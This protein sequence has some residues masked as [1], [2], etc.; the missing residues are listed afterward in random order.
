MPRD[1]GSDGPNAEPQDGRTG[2]GPGEGQSFNPAP[3]WHRIAD[4]A[5]RP[6]GLLLDR[7]R[8]IE[9]PV[10][11]ILMPA[12]GA[13]TMHVPRRGATD[14]SDVCMR[15]QHFDTPE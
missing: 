2:H 6:Y 3:I 4:G 9:T 7:R 10:L 11:R 14:L 15:D 1:F 5:P 8:R 13:V 12:G